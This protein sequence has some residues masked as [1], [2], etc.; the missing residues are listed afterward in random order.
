MKEITVRTQRE[1]EAV[2][3]TDRVAAEAKGVK[4]GVLFVFVPHCTAA[5]I[6]NEFEPNIKQDYE[7]LYSMLRREDWKHNAI[8]S[9]ADAHL[10]SATAGGQ[11]FY[12]VKNG[13]LLL[14]TWQRIILVELDGPRERK[15]LVKAI[16]G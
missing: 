10:A 14:G 1:V 3:V 2:D 4:D 16:E 15:I 5:L 8:D 7:K 13:T 12:F 6:T 11:Q 9:N